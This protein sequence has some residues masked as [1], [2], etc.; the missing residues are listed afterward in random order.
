MEIL[1]IAMDLG[2]KIKLINKLLKDNA[3]YVPENFDFERIN[4]YFNQSN[5]T[6]EKIELL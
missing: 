1:L 3:C 5:I 2:I 6:K 4:K